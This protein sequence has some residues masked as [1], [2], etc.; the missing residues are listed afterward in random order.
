MK[1]RTW[2][3]HLG[4]ILTV[5]ISIAFTWLIWFN[6]TTFFQ[7]VGR[8]PVDTSSGVTNASNKRLDDVYTP[9]SLM[10]NET[11][12]K[13]YQYFNHRS[14]IT[15]QAK[16]IMNRVEITSLKTVA[17]QNVPKYLATVNQSHSLILNYP[18]VLPIKYV[19]ILFDKAPKKIA[20]N[21][22]NVDQIIIPTGNSGNT[23]Y[24]LNSKKQNIYKVSVKNLNVKSLMALTKDK[25]TQS[26]ATVLENIGD[27]YRWTYPQ[28]VKLNEYSYLINKESAGNMVAKL[29]GANT[30]ATIT[31]K[32]Q[33]GKTVYSDDA[34]QRMT[35]DNKHGEVEYINYDSN[36]KNKPKV[37]FSKTLEINLAKL[38]SLGVTLDDVRYSNYESKTGEVIYRNYIAGFPIVSEYN[39]GTYSLQNVTSN[40]QRFMFSLYGLQVPLPNT[41]KQKTLPSTSD[42][43]NRLSSIG[44]SSNRVRAIKIAYSWQRNDSSSQVVDLVPT[45]LI[46]VDGRWIDYEQLFQ[47]FGK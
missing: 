2:M 26:V 45:Y 15:N 32:Q 23:I 44:Y 28:G 31:T 37:S 24:F 41:N 35:V 11:T 1:I 47:N 34:N 16:K 21:K 39:Y 20:E 19:C 14:D 5:V 17:K 43:L 36:D 18:D 46:K 3:L 12:T 33:D 22:E 30:S 13:K 10:Y 27:G 40:G 38:N 6:P 8:T 42:I 29:L 7:N 25:H 4:L 9:T